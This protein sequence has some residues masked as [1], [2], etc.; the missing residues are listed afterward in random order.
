MRGS[1]I[2]R[3]DH[4]A[5]EHTCRQITADEPEQ[6]SIL[7]PFGHQPHQDV[8]RHSI[9]EFLQVDSHDNVASVR[10]ELLGGGH[11]LMR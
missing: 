7:H 9:E 5:H 1:L 10:D 6:G 8:V 4:A 11:G 2:H 3:I